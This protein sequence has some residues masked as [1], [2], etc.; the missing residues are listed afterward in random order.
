VPWK[1][2]NTVSIGTVF[3][4]EQS[5]GDMHAKVRCNADKILVEGAMMN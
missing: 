5:S 4:I 1:P 2:F 3:V